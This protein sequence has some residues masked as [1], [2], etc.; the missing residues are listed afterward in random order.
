MLNVYTGPQLAE[1]LYKAGMPL[2][3][4]YPTEC[5]IA[6][7]E[8]VVTRYLR[9]PTLWEVIDWFSS[10]GIDIYVAPFGKEYEVVICTKQ[11]GINKELP[12]ILVPM[13]KPVECAWMAG[14]FKALEIRK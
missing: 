7:S 2:R 6:V 13:T 14:I 11:N 3:D 8:G 5:N 10:T 4:C 1:I 9:Q 12:N